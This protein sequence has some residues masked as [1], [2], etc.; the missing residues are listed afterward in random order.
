MHEQI[1]AQISS[2]LRIKLLQ[3]NFQLEIM[4]PKQLRAS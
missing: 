1:L 3:F 4:E 2:C